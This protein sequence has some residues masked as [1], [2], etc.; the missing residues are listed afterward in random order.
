MN[1]ANHDVSYR[2]LIRAGVFLGIGMVVVFDPWNR[3]SLSLYIHALHG[4]RRPNP[5]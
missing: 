1:E 4:P 2:P 3:A 5:C